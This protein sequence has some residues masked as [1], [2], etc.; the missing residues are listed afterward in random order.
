MISFHQI[1]ICLVNLLIASIQL[2]LKYIHILT[3]ASKLTVYTPADNRNTASNDWQCSHTPADNR[4][5][6]WSSWQ[7]AR[8]LRHEG[9]RLHDVCTLLP[10]WGRFAI[11]CWECALCQLLVAAWRLSAVVYF[12][13]YMRQICGCLQRV[14]LWILPEVTDIVHAHP[15]DIRRPA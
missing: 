3:Y 15:A 7:S 14:G 8:Y 5:F 4:R 6:V 11:I 9:C 2:I 10:T 12:I 1:I 13:R